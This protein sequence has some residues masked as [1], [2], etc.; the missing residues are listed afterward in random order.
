MV[1]QFLLTC[2]MTYKIAL[3]LVAL[4]ATSPYL[5]AQNTIRVS[6]LP[7]VTS[8]TND[9]KVLVSTN[10]LVAPKTASITLSN[11][12]NSLKGMP[13][14]AQ[15]AINVTNLAN[16]SVNNTEFQYLDGVTSA[17]Q[18]QLDSKASV[19][20]TVDSVA[21]LRL[22]SDSTISTNATARTRGYATSLDGGGNL[23][24]YDATDSTTADNGGSVII[25]ALGHRWKQQDIY[26]YNILQWGAKGDGLQSSAIN[27]ELRMQALFSYIDVKGGEAEYLVPDT[28]AIYY[29]APDAQGLALSGPFSRFTL[30]IDG[31]IKRPDTNGYAGNIF[32]FVGT[33]FES[34]TITGRGT[35]DGNALNMTSGSPNYGKE[36]AFRVDI[37]TNLVLSGL[38]IKNS[39]YALNAS[40]GTNALVTGVTVS[41]LGNNDPIWGKNAD[42]IHFFNCSEV[43]IIGNDIKTTD[44]CI[45]FT[46]LYTNTVNSGIEIIGNHL[47]PYGGSLSNPPEAIRIGVESAGAGGEINDILIASN[48]IDCRAAAVGITLGGNSVLTYNT[49]Y[50]HRVKI[51]DNIIRG[52][53]GFDLISIGPSTGTNITT[54]ALYGSIQCVN[55]YDVELN[56]NILSDQ[57]GSGLVV[58]NCGLVSVN[59]GSISNVIANTDATTSSTSAIRLDLSVSDIGTVKLG[60][61]LLIDGLAASGVL[62][63]TSTSNTLANFVVDGIKI[64]AANMSAAVNSSTFGAIHLLKTTTARIRNAVITDGN[65]DGIV[66]EGVPTSSYFIEDCTFRNNNFTGSVGTVYNIFVGTLSSSSAASGKYTISGCYCGTYNSGM[67]FLQ[68]C[69]DFNLLNNSFISRDTTGTPNA[70][71]IGINYGAG[72]TVDTC[73][74]EGH[75]N[76]FNI[77]QS[78]GTPT[79]TVRVTNTSGHIVTYKWGRNP[80]LNLASFGFGDST[81]TT[82]MTTRNATKWLEEMTPTVRDNTN[83][84]LSNGALIFNSTANHIEQRTPGTW[85]SI[86][87]NLTNSVASVGNVGAGEDDLVVF[88]VPAGVLASAGDSLAFDVTGTFA[89]NTNTKQVKVKFG[90][91]TLIDSTSQIFNGVTWRA[92]GRISRVTATTQRA[93]CELTVGGTLLSAINSTIALYTTPAETLANAI[94]FKCTGTDTGGVPA[95][96][97]VVQTM[98]WIAF[99]PAGPL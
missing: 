67:A 68:N 17:L 57:R 50:F 15:S 92:H 54:S 75:G 62:M 97:A 18:T 90:A 9:D 78:G 84:T 94:T 83:S 32:R 64:H 41:N 52:A 73:T 23:F 26:H 91:T 42:G 85:S 36:A 12:L 45:A 1:V 53:G 43:R 65:T 56:N 28:G 49:R 76:L 13:N 8:V 40:Q 58:R 25:D 29:V 59:G 69:E 31:Y 10:T 3:L 98:E 72:I 5:K 35:V 33:G 24:Y 11:L 93:T 77:T 99:V 48:V 96:N 6:N 7:T 27:N 51:N 63:I 79:F 22:L 20:G 44:D 60:G 61:D 30:R 16:G 66:I 81:A 2:Y 95:D 46:Q 70:N 88:T 86:S 4:I 38:T 55:V 74:F 47:S 14:W 37:F 82:N 19:S 80:N 39:C 71:A 21:A 34:L 87:G 89:A